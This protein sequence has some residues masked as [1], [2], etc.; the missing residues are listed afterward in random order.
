MIKKFYFIFFLNVKKGFKKIV[1]KKEIFFIRKVIFSL[2]HCNIL[3]TRQKIY[4]V[5]KEIVIKQFLTQRLLYQKFT[6][7]FLFF[8][9]KNRSIVYP[10]TLQWIKNLKNQKIKVN[11][12][13]SLLLFNL[14]KIYNLTAG[15][16]FF[17]KL[18]IKIFISKLK[19]K[20]K[21]YN[22]FSIF[23][24]L[25]TDKIGL[26][27]ND[28]EFTFLNWL[29]KKYLITEHIVF[30][31]RLNKDITNL[32]YSIRK[33]FHEIFFDQINFFSFFYK[34]VK[35]II[36][37]P[38]LKNYT[39][40]LILF[41]ETIELF[42]FQSIKNINLKEIYFIWTNNIYRPLWTYEL[43]K[44]GCKVIVFFNGYINEIRTNESLKL[45]YDYEGLSLMTWTN[46]LFWEKEN[47]EFLSDR[48]KFNFNSKIVG[49]TYLRDKNLNVEIPKNSISVFGYE[50]H[51]KNIGIAT[52]GDYENY[53]F[54]FLETF[55]NNIYNFLKKKHF[56]MIIKRK[57]NLNNLEI[58]KNRVFF[59]NLCKSSTVINIDPDISPF[60]I[61]KKTKG[62][63]SMPF[64][65][66]AAIA[67]LYKV[68]SIYYDPFNWIQKNDP[69]ACGTKIVSNLEN[70]NKWLEV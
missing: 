24:N 13:F 61:I 14:F 28:S 9:K 12:L 31:D 4:N 15:I 25:N 45:C 1:K 44:R 59:N 68:K 46:Y 20:K 55:Y 10:L 2:T 50:N 49:P 65:S 47:L 62:V 5:D 7:V 18:C 35:F 38:F 34:S 63:I 19:L 57:N 53:N 39:F 26:E 29:K 16:I 52:I 33:N 17:F 6:W 41:K 37:L 30:I 23:Y 27:N 43:E 64:T 21:T 51:K 54:K 48:N 32:N 22:N 67:K 70:I 40:N 69:S 60:Q 42:F 66:T 58:K 11:L 36:S 3:K 56:Y 8:Y